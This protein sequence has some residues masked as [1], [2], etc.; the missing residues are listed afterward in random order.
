MPGKNASVAWRSRSAVPRGPGDD[1]RTRAA[2]D[3]RGMHQQKRQTAEVVPVEM[4][5]D[6]RVD[7]ERVDAVTI[8]RYERRGTEVDQQ[9]RRG[10]SR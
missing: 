10:V 9:F 5:H 6:D 1:Q 8:H 2:A 7:G 4:A 3:E